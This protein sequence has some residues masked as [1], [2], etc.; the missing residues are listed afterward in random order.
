VSI[1][2]GIEDEIVDRRWSLTVSPEDEHDSHEDRRG[3]VLAALRYFGTY[4]TS[5]SIA[6]YTGLDLN[7]V[8]DTLRELVHEEKADLQ[9]SKYFIRL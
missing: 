8:K 9:N 7:V 6:L 5:G 1:D 4:E 3:A 2:E